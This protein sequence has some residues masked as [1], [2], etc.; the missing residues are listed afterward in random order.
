MRGKSTNN[1]S[2]QKLIFRI[3]PLSAGDKLERTP[4]AFLCS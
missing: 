3:K 2:V 4:V 1:V